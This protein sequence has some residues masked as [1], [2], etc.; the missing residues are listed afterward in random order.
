[1]GAVFYIVYILVH[2]ELHCIYIKRKLYECIIKL[3]TLCLK[4]VAPI[5]L[6]DNQI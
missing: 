5:M 6:P 1:M 2:P 3:D 4:I